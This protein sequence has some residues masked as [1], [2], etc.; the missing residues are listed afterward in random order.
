MQTKRTNNPTPT[1]SKFNIFFFTLIAFSVFI[2]MGCSSPTSAKKSA[3]AC[4]KDKA[5]GSTVKGETSQDTLVKAAKA[6]GKGVIV[7]ALQGEGK[8]VI[9]GLLKTG[10]NAAGEQ[11]YLNTTPVPLEGATILIFD[12]LRATT[13]AETTLTTD[14]KGNYSAVLKGGKYYGFAVHLDLQTFRLIT[15]SIPFINCKKDSLAKMDTAIAIEDV[16]NPS[17][18]GVYDATSPDASGLFLSGPIPAKN[19]KITLMF[20]E[21]MQRESVKGLVVGRIDANNVNGTFLLRDSISSSSLIPSWSG[22][23]KQLTLSMGSL[24]SGTRYGIIIPTS[25]KDLAKNPLEKEYKAVFEAASDVKVAD[26]SFTVSSTFPTEKE[27]LKPTQNP[28]ISFSRPP[29]VFSV[30]NA[31][32]LD[33]KVEGYW[34]VTGAK[35]SFVH[36]TPFKV[37]TSYTISVPDTLSDLNGKHLDNTFKVTF[38]VKDYE[39][40]AKDKTGRDQAVAL[41]MEEFFNAYLQ[42]DIGRMAGYLDPA[43]RMEVGTQFL[44][45]QQFLDQIRREVSEKNGLTAGFLAPI[46]R[47]NAQVCSTHTALR[48]VASVDKKDTLWVQAHSSP[49]I[50]PKVY[51]KE[52]PVTTGITWS[53]TDNRLSLDGKDFIF[54]VPSSNTMNNGADDRFLGEQLKLNSSVVLELVKE[55]IKDEFSIDGGISVTDQEAKVAVKV[56]TVISHG[57]NNWDPQL[58]CAEAVPVDTSYR[59]IKF[60]LGFTGTKWVLNH[61][62]DGGLVE[63][64]KFTELVA[65]TEFKVKE[66]KPITL[67]GPINGVEGAGGTS[68]TVV[69]RFRGLDLDSVGGYLVG[70]AEDPKFT[71]GRASYGAL[72]FVKNQ[73]VGKEQNFSLNEKAEIINGATSLLR[74]VSTLNL[75]GWEKAVFKFPASEMFN[76]EKGIAGI[77]HWKVI[78]I[79]DTSGSQFLVN[80]FLPDRFYGESDFGGSKGAFAFKGYPK[81]ADFTKLDNQVAMVATAQSESQSFSDKDLD[82]YPDFMEVNYKTKPDDKASFPNFLVDTDRDGIADFLEQMINP[83]N[84]EIEASDADKK[85]FFATL[86]GKGVK[87][88]DTDS[89]GIPDDVEKLLGF[90]PNDPL[91]KPV[92]HARVS[93][94]SGIFSGLIKMGSNAYPLKFKVRQQADS[95]TVSYSVYLKDTLSDTVSA[96]LNEAM[97][98]FL[99]PIR[100]PDNGPDSGK[101][102]LLRGTYEKNRVFLSGSV[103]RINTVAKNSIAFAGGPFVGQYAASGR[104]E[105][106]SPFLGIVK[107]TGATTTTTTPASTLTPATL[108]TFSTANLS[109]RKAP[110]GLGHARMNLSQGVGK[111]FV[112]TILDEFG[113]TSVVLDSTHSYPQEDGTF[114]IDAKFTR[115]NSVKQYI[116]RVILTARLGR[117][118]DST[119]SVWV[120]D[121]SMTESVDSCRRFDAITP[122]KCLDKLYRDVPGQFSSMVKATDASVKVLSGSILG[123]YAGWFQQDKFGT[124]L[125]DGA[126]EA[127]QN[128]TTTTGMGG[129]PV[130]A[131]PVPPESFSKT[132]TGDAVKFGAFLGQAGILP[133][134]PFYLS[135]RGRVMRSTYD[136][137]HI[138]NGAFPYCGNVQLTVT[139]IP[140]VDGA[141]PSEKAAFTKDSLLATSAKYTVLAIE[142]EALPGSPA[143]LVKARDALAFVRSNVFLIESRFVDPNTYLGGK[144]LDGSILPPPSPLDAGFP[145]LPTGTAY[146][147]G[148]LASLSAALNSSGNKITIVTAGTT[149]TRVVEINPA[150]LR[151]DPDSKAAM[152][153]NVDDPSLG[154]V[155]LGE[156]GKASTPQIVAGQPTGLAI[157]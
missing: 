123:N 26:L 34:E 155:L 101:S 139:P 53:K 76:P 2:W 61:A 32:T 29:Q 57:R 146:F 88:I 75:P 31:V 59:I 15:A 62:V 124:G 68:G 36:K 95:L 33:P 48:K 10:T 42:G 30:L 111:L 153:A 84:V 128:A 16:T 106:V 109:Y 49:G 58:A 148:D 77:Y 156:A 21:P 25:L 72:F 6:A 133:G 97:G 96:D 44:S 112:L 80:G 99:F 66:I 91:S 85:A 35:I 74:D 122:T 102:L 108:A 83:A 3:C 147:R 13:A 98:E 43:F 149:T 100:L 4:E 151:I 67:L 145:S 82:G 69:F 113:D 40:A 9:K 78:A 130:L 27:F 65:T 152:A 142:D 28:Q 56:S 89:D 1:L 47:A 71:G 144:C 39:G 131:D 81:A 17:V 8:D 103:N 114:D 129:L 90:N 110:S 105:D 127:A 104:G 116:R 79:R 125:V 115:T 63:R 70:V 135:M 157:P 92:T 11:R 137:L 143:K 138:Q 41:L 140:L 107:N 37:G 126:T 14:K 60:I 150:T 86:T 23:S 19:A 154:Y 46:Y 5:I 12:A 50:L 52:I 117:G 45:S 7:G 118:K 18:T 51:R 120:L 119:T 93:P 134:D 141:T 94:P 38:G 121:G 24:E 136:S 20:S 132:Y 64:K 55:G 73:G 22:D 87:W 54:D